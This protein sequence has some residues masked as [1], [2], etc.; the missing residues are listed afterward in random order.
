MISICHKFMPIV[1]T[2]H[3]NLYLLGDKYVMYL[4]KFI[5]NMHGRSQN[6]WYVP[7]NMEA[8]HP[9]EMNASAATVLWLMELHIACFRKRS[10]EAYAAMVMNRSTVSFLMHLSCMSPLC[11]LPPA[12]R[13]METTRPASLQAHYH[14]LSLSLSQT[15]YPCELVIQA[16]NAWNGVHL[17]TYTHLRLVRVWVFMGVLECPSRDIYLC[18]W[19]LRAWAPCIMWCCIP[20]M[21]PISLWEEYSFSISLMIQKVRIP[22]CRLT[23]ELTYL[24]SAPERKI[25]FEEHMCLPLFLGRNLYS[26]SATRFF[27]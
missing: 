19:T 13:K 3:N 11:I 20:R 5:S 6:D 18:M 27:V 9:D 10:K 26:S 14:A 24:F 16:C 15:L 25:L 8:I 12:K 21:T 2:K 17:H 23:C 7:L 22:I 4:I 1:S